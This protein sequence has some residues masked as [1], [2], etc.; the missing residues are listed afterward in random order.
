MA[1]DGAGSVPLDDILRDLNRATEQ[2]LPERVEAEPE[3]RSAK[4][5]AKLPEERY[6]TCSAFIEALNDALSGRP[7]APPG[8]R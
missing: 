5:L 7:P 1:Y 3:S 2:E 6:A 4:A 8:T